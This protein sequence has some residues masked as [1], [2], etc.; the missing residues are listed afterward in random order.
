[1][2]A[3]DRVDDNRTLC[4][5]RQVGSASPDDRPTM[6]IKTES[7]AGSRLPMNGNQHQFC[8]SVVVA[9]SS[10]VIVPAA[11]VLMANVGTLLDSTTNSVQMKH[12]IVGDMINR[13]QAM[14]YDLNQEIV[15]QVR[16]RTKCL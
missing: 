16:P 1:M 2:F 15:A 8:S 4:I 14:R 6:S 7:S 13:L 5:H 11:A 9:P 12:K 10:D 3:F